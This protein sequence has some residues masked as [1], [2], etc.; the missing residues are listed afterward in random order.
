[1]ARYQS[2]NYYDDQPRI[3]ARPQND[4]ATQAGMRGVHRDTGGNVIGGYSAEGK[5]YGTKKRAWQAPVG[6]RTG[7]PSTPGLDRLAA[8]QPG[9]GYRAVNPY[10]DKTA[11]ATGN[12]L[13]SRQNLYKQMQAAGPDGLNE[14]MRAK[15]RSLG[16]TDSGFNM[17]A[18]RIKSNAAAIAPPAKTAAVVPP[19]P[20]APPT[21]PVP[22]VPA[23][24]PGSTTPP[25][26]TTP[27]PDPTTAR[28]TV[29]PNSTPLGG[30]GG[31]SW[32]RQREMA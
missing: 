10:T 24:T 28:R 8:M 7:N 17:A 18:G 31:R 2:R 16:V 26:P 3:D 22:P 12:V 25:A 4:P 23:V 27:P 20:A 30:G 6:F 15:A 19:V 14:D 29:N 21:A 9:A 11:A 13:N 5:A 32:R 1:M